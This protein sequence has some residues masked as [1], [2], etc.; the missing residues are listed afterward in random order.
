MGWKE[1]NQLVREVDAD[2]DAAFPFNSREAPDLPNSSIDVAFHVK[3]RELANANRSTNLVKLPRIKHFRFFQGS[4][5]GL[6]NPETSA[7]LRMSLDHVIRNSF[8]VP[9]FIDLSRNKKSIGRGRILLEPVR[10]IPDARR[11]HF[12]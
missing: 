1:I 5:G 11:P 9:G 12:L 6:P 7:R 4:H 3:G 8:D 10:P 2:L